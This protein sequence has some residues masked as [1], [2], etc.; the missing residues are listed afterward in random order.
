MESRI[1]QLHYQWPFLTLKATLE[2]PNLGKYKLNTISYRAFTDELET[3][4]AL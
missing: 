1:E 2:V 4:R 3:T